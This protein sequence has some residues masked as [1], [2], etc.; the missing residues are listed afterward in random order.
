LKKEKTKSGRMAK[1]M[2]AACCDDKQAIQGGE[3]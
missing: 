3:I 2:S 1:A